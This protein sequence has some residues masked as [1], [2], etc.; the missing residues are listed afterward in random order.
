MFLFLGISKSG[1]STHSACCTR[2]LATV[3][4]LLRPQSVVSA[5]RVMAGNETVGRR[6]FKPLA[7]ASIS[8]LS[9]PAYHSPLNYI[10]SYKEDVILPQLLSEATL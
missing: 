1:T 9:H 5:T 4:C 2:I 7:L 3:C 10:L 6:Y 8:S